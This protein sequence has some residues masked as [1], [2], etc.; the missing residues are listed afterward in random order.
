VK[1]ADRLV[2]LTL[3]LL[4]AAVAVFAYLNMGDAELR[5]ALEE[6]REFRVMVDGVLL[7][8]ISLQTLVDLDPKEFTTT[9]A[10]SVSAA[11]ETTLRGVELRVI[12]ELLNID[13][14]NASRILISGLDSYYSPIS[15]AEARKEDTVY[16]CFSM[17]GE[18][19]K[20]RSEGGVGPFMM[21][22][23]GSIFAQRWCKY[24]EAVDVI[25]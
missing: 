18:I 7:A 5:R 13:I 24:V 12:L 19:M 11:R 10:T 4:L 21:V 2:Y 22:I 15:V 9:Y 23:R 3:A 1:N 16:I 8:T 17:D 25:S 14:S 20:P 6:N